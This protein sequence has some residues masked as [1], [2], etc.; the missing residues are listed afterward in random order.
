M[1]PSVVL[2]VAIL[3]SIPGGS[4]TVP[5][6]QLIRLSD[7]PGRPLA[8]IVRILEE[9]HGWVI[10]YE[11]PH[12]VYAEEISDVTHKVSRNHA[13]GKPR[14]L[15]PRVRGFDFRYSTPVGRDALGASPILERLLAAYH[16][17][18]NPGKFRFHSAGPIIHV[19]P[20]MARDTRG[21]LA[22]YEPVLDA[23]IEMPLATRTA[24]EMLDAIVAQVAVAR[25]TKVILG[26]VPVNL[27]QTTTVRDAVTNEVAR[28]ALSRTLEATG[29][30]L[31]W[32]LFYGPGTRRYVL[33]VH[34]VPEAPR[35]LRD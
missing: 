30:K 6:E 9:R 16:R 28:D 10:T 17:S 32:Q 26:T 29:R 4:R 35:L 15:V 7:D 33:N 19:V 27:L 8:E 14:V 24:L 31:S 2:A 18:G 13:P 1:H 34:L 20:A 11:D 5:Q 12:Y 22:P 3:G 25:G 21:A 23:R